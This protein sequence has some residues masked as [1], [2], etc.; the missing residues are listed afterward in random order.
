MRKTLENRV[1]PEPK[2][3]SYFGGCPVCGRTDGFFN[4]RSCHF[5][6]CE[7]H[8]VKWFVGFNL[9]RA[10]RQETPEIWARNAA[11]YD[12]YADVHPVLPDPKLSSVT[13]ADAFPLV[14]VQSCVWT[15]EHKLRPSYLRGLKHS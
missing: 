6:V 5:F 15:V 3:T 11:R 2:T 14:T 9:F 1:S 8:R 10:W 7:A 12:D 4:L 13:P